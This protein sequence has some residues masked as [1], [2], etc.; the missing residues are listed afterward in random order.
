MNVYYLQSLDH[1][2]MALDFSSVT[3]SMLA[4]R[5]NRRGDATSTI[6][7]E[8]DKKNLLE[9]INRGRLLIERRKVGAFSPSFSLLPSCMAV[10][11]A[12]HSLL[13]LSYPCLTLC[14]SSWLHLHFTW[15]ILPAYWINQRSRLIEWPVNHGQL[16]S[17]RSSVWMCH[18]WSLTWLSLSVSLLWFTFFLSSTISP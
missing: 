10:P 3:H 17:S 11:I 1:K 13:T 9:N 5:R 4:W 14:Y 6:I 7:V 8:R 18:P 16:L 15:T 12:M 2:Q